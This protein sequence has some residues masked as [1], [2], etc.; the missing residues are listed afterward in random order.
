LNWKLPSDIKKELKK[1]WEQGSLFRGIVS[2]DIEFPYIVTIKPPT[3]AEMSQK[4]QQAREW[5]SKFAEESQKMGCTMLT[6]EVNHR[7]LGSN[8]LPR[9]LS[10]S[11]VKELILFIGKNREYEKYLQLSAIA[12]HSF[13]EL[14][15]WYLHRP[16]ELL[17][18]EQDLS[19]ILN[20]LSWFQVYRKNTQSAESIEKR[21]YLRQVSIQGIDTKFIEKHAGLLGRL[22][23]LVCPDESFPEKG[24]FAAKFGFLSKPQLIRF[25]ILDPEKY[26]SGLSDISVP[27]GDFCSLD[28]PIKKIFVAEND[29]NALTF[30]ELSDS[31]VIFGRGYTFDYLQEAHWLHSKQLYY[32]G[33]IDTHGFAILNQFRGIFPHARSILMDL[34]TLEQHRLQWGIEEKQINV[35]LER[36]NPE[37]T[38]IY[39][40]LR[41]NKIQQGLRLEQELI[42]YNFAITRIQTALPI[43]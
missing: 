40:Q 9:A 33:D 16:H 11:T 42:S 13:P 21:L 8:S 7:Q 19:R 37:E 26:I 5:S 23:Q 18:V 31:M 35:D 39:D 24:S 28:L 29:I 27:A 32:W 22:I 30:P 1:K 14:Q 12:S 17:A 41:F 25:R 3:S 10:F 43:N 6:K 38:G 2:E 34:H 15:T 36:L 4:F 20:F